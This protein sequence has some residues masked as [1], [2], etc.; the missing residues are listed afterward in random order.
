MNSFSKGTSKW[1]LYVLYNFTLVYPFEINK[2]WLVWTWFS[3][4]KFPL[5]FSSNFPLPR[6]LSTLLFKDAGQKYMIK[7]D[8]KGLVYVQ[9]SRIEEVSSIEELQETFGTW[10]KLTKWLNWKPKN[11]QSF[12]QV[13]LSVRSRIFFVQI[14]RSSSQYKMIKN[15]FSR[16][17][18]VNQGNLRKAFPWANGHFFSKWTKF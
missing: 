2:D 8:K 17:S 1:R 11:F 13:I 15:F 16:F 5:H 7:K 18:K 10:F 12:I 4:S 3:I 6:H 9:N 14:Y